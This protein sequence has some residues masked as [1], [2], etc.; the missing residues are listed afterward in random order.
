ML[1]AHEQG[2]IT[3]WQILLDVSEK[4]SNI[5]WCNITANH[6]RLK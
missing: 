6:Q 4:K 2:D 1:E 5:H 3:P